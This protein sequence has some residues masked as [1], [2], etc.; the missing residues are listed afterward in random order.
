MNIFHFPDE[1]MKQL[2]VAG[3]FLFGSQAV[4]ATHA[5]SDYDFGILLTQREIL[6][7]Y[8]KRNIVYDQ[9]YDLLAT[10]IQQLVNIDI[11]FLQDTDLQLR[12]HVLRD[13]QLQYVGDQ[14]VVSDFMEQ[15]MELYCDFA[16]LRKEFQAAVLARI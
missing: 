11:V 1:Q 7:D 3:V 14:K 16:P 12:Y 8:K 15:T 4:G 9:L 13:G 6:F 2:G 5:N 10:Q